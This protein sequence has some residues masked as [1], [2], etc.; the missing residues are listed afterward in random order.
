MTGDTN[1]KYPIPCDVRMYTREEVAE[2]SDE[3]PHK[4]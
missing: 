4:L 1:N 3:A 2:S